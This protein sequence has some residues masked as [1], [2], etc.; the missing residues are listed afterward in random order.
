VLVLGETGTGK[1]VIA[2]AIHDRSS[3]RDRPLVKVNCAAISAGLVESELFG[4]VRGAFTGAVASRTGRFEV[5]HGGTLFL[6]EIGELPL[7]TQVKLLRV[8]QEREIEPVGSNQSKKVDVRVIAATNRDLE[9]AVAEG[10]FRSD[11]FF[12]VNVFPIETAA[13]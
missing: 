2:R 7:E 12:R 8:L 5:A 11:L 13:P 10:R 6:D 9:R 4:H 1:E 3:R